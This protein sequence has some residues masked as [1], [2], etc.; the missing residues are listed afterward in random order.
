[1]FPSRTIIGKL[2]GRFRVTMLIDSGSEMNV[3]SKELWEKVQDHLPIETDVSCSIGSVN[4]THN[5]VY[6]L[7]HLVMVDIGG[8]EIKGPVFFLEGTAQKFIIGRP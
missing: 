2:E 4:L 6:G 1:M 3:M 5:R 8:I 7:C